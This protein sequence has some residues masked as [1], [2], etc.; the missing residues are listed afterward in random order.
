MAVSAAPTNCLWVS[1][2]V[3]YW[4]LGHW[5]RAVTVSWLVV[6]MCN[7]EKNN[8]I[9]FGQVGFTSGAIYIYIL[10]RIPGHIPTMTRT[11]PIFLTEDLRKR[12]HNEDTFF[13]HSSPLF[14]RIADSGQLTPFCCCDENVGEVKEKKTLNQVHNAE[15]QRFEAK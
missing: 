13:R 7:D 12:L 2:D 4:D 14:L 9:I 6:Y 11:L 8:D 10:P 1:E 15:E 5:G 3:S